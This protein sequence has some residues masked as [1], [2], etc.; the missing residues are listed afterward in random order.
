MI[1][2]K[3]ITITTAVLA[4]CLVVFGSYV[5]ISDAG[6]GCP[7]WPGC[8]GILTVP[9]SRI[10]IDK[11]MANFPGQVIETEK[12]WIEMIHRYVA[13]ILGLLILVIGFYAFKYRKILEI[14][15]LLPYSLLGVVLFQATLGMLTV[16]LLLKPIIVTS[17]LI[18]GMLTL[19]LL[20]AISAQHL[21]K[22]ST[23]IIKNHLFFYIIRFSLVLIF[24]QIFLGGWT[25]TNYAG[26]AC[27][28]YPKCHGMWFP[29]MDFQN[30]FSINRDLG[31]TPEGAS[32][33]L[34]ALQAI[35][36]VHRLGAIIVTLYFIYLSYALMKYK[37]LKLEATLLIILI[38]YQ[39]LLGIAN[40]LLHLPVIL[41][42]LHNFGAAA[43]V[44]ILTII[45][46]KIK[47]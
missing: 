35:Q 4:F 18:G 38:I 19:A 36:W 37:Q 42:A 8:F 27:T 33:S 34:S 47:K 1:F 44:V 30:A 25:S 15:M 40:I 10:A 2:F 6:L 22:N 14:N 23:L 16:T 29:D 12:A 46:S 21:N 41:A 3:S 7:D 32:I 5:R 11:A 9:E 26:L 17:H 20:T 31:K 43:L 24:L 45:N 39:F 13:G 28:D